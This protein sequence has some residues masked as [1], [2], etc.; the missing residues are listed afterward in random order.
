MS[1][2]IKMFHTGGFVLHK[3]HLPIARRSP[4]YYSA[5][6]DKDRNLLDAEGFSNTGSQINVK[7]GG[8][9]WEALMAVGNHVILPIP[10]ENEKEQLA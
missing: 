3:V 9:V 6:F 1:M 7:V 8:Q 10:P 4:Q 2:Q 5:W